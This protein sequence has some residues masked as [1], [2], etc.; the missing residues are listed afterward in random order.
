MKKNPILTRQNAD[1][2]LKWATEKVGWSIEWEN[3]IY[4]DEKSLTWMFQ[5]VGVVIGVISE[6]MRNIYAEDT[7]VEWWYGPHFWISNKRGTP[8]VP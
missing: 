6:S 2:R 7:A 3:V 4:S 1:R 5:A 8:F